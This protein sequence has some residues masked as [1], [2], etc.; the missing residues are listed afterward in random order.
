MDWWTGVGPIQD[1]FRQEFDLGLTSAIYDGLGNSARSHAVNPKVPFQCSTGNCTWPTFTSA[2][3][4]STCNDVTS[5]LVKDYNSGCEG[6]SGRDGGCTTFSASY[7]SIGQHDGA[8][9]DEGWTLDDMLNPMS[10]LQYSA[11]AVLLT[12]N[13]TMDYTRT[14][15]FKELKTIFV[16]YLV[17]R[18]SDD[19]VRNETAWKDST[20][21]ATECGL[22]FCAKAFNS[23][24]QNGNL[25][26]DQL[27]QWAD[28]DPQSWKMGGSSTVEFMEKHPSLDPINYYLTDLVVTVPGNIAQEMEVEPRFNIT[29]ATVTGLQESLKTLT[30]DTFRVVNNG[31]ETTT[32]SAVKYPLSVR[33]TYDYPFG[34]I[35]WNSTNTTAVFDRLAN[36]LTVEFRSSLPS[37]LAGTLHLYSL[38]IK[39]VWPYLL[40][41]ACAVAMGWA[42]LTLVVLQTRRVGLP[43]VKESVYP[44]LAYGFDEGTQAFLRMLEVGPKAALNLRDNLIISLADGH[45]GMRLEISGD[46]TCTDQKGRSKMDV[47]SFY[48]RGT[49]PTAEGNGQTSKGAD[50]VQLRRVASAPANFDT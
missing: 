39:V 14:I 41:P 2:G 9:L 15:S 45:D 46:S 26:E 11:G 27:G 28:R 31:T 40:L 29:Q 16:S 38:H 1:P 8:L 43:V 34:E 21:T 32:T 25:I 35:L 20:P 5:A 6:N 17:I 3:V 24:V 10:R 33:A 22:Y 49:Q 18:V 36:R 23:R 48:S 42:Y 12:S 19:F 50:M 13:L 47:E 4:C 30:L 37:K 7:G 44:T